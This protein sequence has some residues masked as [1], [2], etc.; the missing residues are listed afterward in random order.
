MKAIVMEVNDKNIIIMKSNGEF[1][2]I[3]TNKEFK[4]GDEIDSSLF[5]KH[6]ILSN[7]FNT[8]KVMIMRI[9]SVAAAL[10]LIFGMAYGAYSYNVPYSY[11]SIDINPSIEIIVNRYD[12]IIGLEGIDDDGKIIAGGLSSYKHTL[13]NKG[14]Q[15]I[16]NSA[17]Q[18]GYINKEKDN[19]VFMTLSSKD[20][21]KM[22]QLDKILETTVSEQI[23]STGVNA[24][25]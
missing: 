2:K 23:Q 3:R 4:V 9:T 17:V 18:E 8:S 21:N 6:L 10:I 14:I 19:T 24:E 1:A 20:H 11:I 5:E 22:D 7:L 13:I 16:I 25:L 15:D 12:R